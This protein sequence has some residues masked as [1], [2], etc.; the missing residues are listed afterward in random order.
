MV[1]LLVGIVWNKPQEDQ[2][3]KTF[4]CSVWESQFTQR[5]K[6]GHVWMAFLFRLS[7]EIMCPVLALMHGFI[8]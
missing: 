8:E 7:E 4:D 1:I 2:Y 3:E 5:Q 6:Q